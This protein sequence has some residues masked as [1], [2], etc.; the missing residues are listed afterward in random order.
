MRII[1][2]IFFTL[3]SISTFSQ[4][5]KFDTLLQQGKDEFHKD[6]DKQN[7]NKGGGGSFA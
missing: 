7:F 6:F 5:L 4:S 2:V 1:A 3:I